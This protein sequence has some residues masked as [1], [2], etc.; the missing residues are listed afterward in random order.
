MK[1]GGAPKQLRLYR[2][3]RIFGRRVE[4]I[5]WRN[6]A[7]EKFVSSQIMMK[8]YIRYFTNFCERT[9]Q[10]RSHLIAKAAV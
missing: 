4:V 3:G 9:V 1:D 6:V 7:S 5:C 8:G 10:E 2:E